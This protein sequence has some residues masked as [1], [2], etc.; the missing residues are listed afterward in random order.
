VTAS[1]GYRRALT[2]AG[3]DSGGGAGI[4]ADLKTF[5]AL[6]CYGMSAL[7]ALTAQNT[8]GVQA[9]H[10][11]PPA[12]ITAQI[13]S[14]F[15][16]IGADATKVGMVHSVP[17]IAAVAAGL[18]VHH[19]A[20]VVVDPV[21]V[22]T[23]GDPL[24][25]PDAVNTLRDLLVP[26]AT[27]LTPNLPEAALLLGTDDLGFEI[28]DACHA[29]AD[30]G[31]DAVLIKGGHAGGERSV[32][33]LY[34]R[35]TQRLERFDAPRIDTDNTHGTGCTL[36]SAIA[37]HLARGVPIP[38]AVGAAKAYL[39]QAL[40]AGAKRRLGAGRGPV[41]HFFDVWDA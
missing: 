30:L 23:S 8:L 40:Q 10:P 18:R 24:L 5:A 20:N 39:T 11:V 12:F 1:S 26:A 17:A 38:D 7:T 6:G 36:S 2:I 29:L 3:S 25:E 32:D 33:V 19:A 21:M 16:D 34:V 37:A 41:H 28:E 27:V 14:V 13:D 22:A 4:Q 15:S 31:A 35:D 9:I